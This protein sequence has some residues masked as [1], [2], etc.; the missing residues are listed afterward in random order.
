M[1]IHKKKKLDDEFLV[2]I[3]RLEAECS[4]E[5]IPQIDKAPEHIKKMFWQQAD[6]YMTSKYIW[7]LGECKKYGNVDVYI[8]LLYR[9]MSDKY[10]GTEQIYDYVVSL[11]DIDDIRNVSDVSYYLKEI[12]KQMHKKYID[13]AIKSYELATVE[14][15]FFGALKWRD[16]KCFQKIVK[17]DPG[18]YAEL[19][20]I[21]RRKDNDNSEKMLTEE[22]STYINVMCRLYGEIKFCPAERNGKVIESELRSWIEEF[23]ILLEKNDQKS[24]FSYYIGKMLSYSPAG[25]DG[26]YPCEAVR[27]VL[28]DYADD[29]LISGYVTEKYNSRGIYSPSD[30][31]TEKSLAARYKENA[32]YLSTIYPKTAK[33][34]YRLCDRYKYEAKWERERA[35]NG[36]Y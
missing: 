6:Y 2:G 25:K 5:D 9:A 33:I 12:L 27:N 7:A 13:D 24:L 34:Y 1:E 23:M 10:F 36:V 28:E 29:A 11:K 22:E 15:R 21:T 4:G 3:Y 30:G 16:M 31:R 26:Y 17:A 19:I 35:E 18:N 32:D 14:I 20:A 8:K